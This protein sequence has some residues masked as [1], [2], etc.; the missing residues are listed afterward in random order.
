[1]SFRISSS[2]KFRDDSGWPV[3]RKQCRPKPYLFS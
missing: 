2:K 3:L 1:M